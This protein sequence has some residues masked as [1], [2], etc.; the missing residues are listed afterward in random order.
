M[1]TVKDSQADIAHML[2]YQHLNGQRRLFGGTLMQWID[3]LAGVVAWRHAGCNITTAAV[4]SLIFKHP[5]HLNELITLSARITYIG[6]TS[7]EVR[8]D[9][10]A[11]KQDGTRLNI[12]TAY[13]VVVATDEDGAPIPVPG[14]SLC[15]PE[16]EQEWAMGEKRYALRRQ[17][18]KEQY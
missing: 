12:N 16:E 10:Y 14:I 4:D 8:V 18:R 17:R 5:A 9:T 13:C 6:R 11:E 3:E 2:R 7:M 1:K 15:T